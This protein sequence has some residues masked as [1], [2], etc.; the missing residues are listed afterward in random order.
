MSKNDR[1]RSVLAPQ[2]IPYV[3]KAVEVYLHNYRNSLSEDDVRNLS[4]LKH[5]LGRIESDGN[6]T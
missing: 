6:Q 2:D 1:P 3:R 4:N 5:R